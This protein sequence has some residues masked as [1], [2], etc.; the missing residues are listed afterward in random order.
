MV[1]KYLLDTDVVIAA[2][3]GKQPTEELVYLGDQG[4]AAALSVITVFEIWEG[5][6]GSKKV[7]IETGEQQFN[8][9]VDKYVEQLVPL[10][11]EIAKI[12]GKLRAQLRRSGQVI[13]DTDILIA[14]TCIVNDLTLVTKNKRH[15]ARIKGLTIF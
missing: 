13:T 1:A 8:Q 7:S 12:A 5:I 3:K 15:F 6:Y 10:D 2:L 4:A 14:A 11:L 9:F